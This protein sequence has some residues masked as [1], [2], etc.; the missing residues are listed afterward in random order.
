[1]SIAAHS[2]SWACELSAVAAM[3][4]RRALGWGVHALCVAVRGDTD[5]SAR[6]FEAKAGQHITD[7]RQLVWIG[8]DADPMTS[9]RPGCMDVDSIGPQRA[10]KPRR[11]RMTRRR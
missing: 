10:E 11:E 9:M 7:P 6:S 2:S 8:M 3:H 4:G 1:M 5:F